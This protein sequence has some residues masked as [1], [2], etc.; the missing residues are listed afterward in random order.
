MLDKNND[1][2]VDYQ[3]IKE[4]FKGETGFDDQDFIEYMK[5]VDTNGD[6]LIDFEEFEAMMKE[7]LSKRSRALGEVCG[8]CWIMDLRLDGLGLK[9]VFY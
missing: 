9:L 5:E 6:G 2:E 8:W 1:G 4:M 3:E 7:L